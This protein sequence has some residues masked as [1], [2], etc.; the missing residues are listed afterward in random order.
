MKKI[1]RPALF[2]LSAALAF[3]GCTSPK[4]KKEWTF[5]FQQDNEGFEPIFAD[6]SDDGNN[7]TTYEMAFG[8]ALTPITADQTQGL[9]I[10]AQNRSDDLFMGFSK[11]LTGLKGNQTYTIKIT[12]K[13]YTDAESGSIGVGGSPAE[14]VYVKAG[15]VNE[16]P[17]LELDDQD[18][19]RLTI[20]KG[21]QSEGSL[22][23]P[24]VSNMAKPEG[25]PEGYAV[26]DLSVTIDL[27]TAADGSVYLV[28]GTDSGFEGFTRY[29]LD[30]VVV[31]ATQK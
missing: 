12:F 31:T 27:K 29:F 3:G 21:N 9:F 6:Y 4:D 28:I 13:L 23:I 16:K 7:L 5:D 26:K 30:D 11:L 10:Q 1:F 14:S 17:E 8:R 15:A 25:S 2:V 19:Y 22:S 24:V 20:D 18:T